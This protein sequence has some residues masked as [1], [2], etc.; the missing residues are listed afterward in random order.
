MASQSDS[1]ATLHP[2]FNKEVKDYNV[3]YKKSTSGGEIQDNL[4]KKLDHKD[5]DKH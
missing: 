3:N 2:E 5:T 4:R 1:G